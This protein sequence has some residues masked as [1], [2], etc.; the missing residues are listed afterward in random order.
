MTIRTAEEG[1]TASNCPHG[2][3]RTIKAE[4]VGGGQ[5]VTWTEAAALDSKPA[6]MV[7]AMP[8]LVLEL[9]EG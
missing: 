8:D 4:L 7:I 1:G 9:S 5:S 3:K 6:H 2:R